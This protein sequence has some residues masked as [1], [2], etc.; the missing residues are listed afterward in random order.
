V[1]R[2]VLRLSVGFARSQRQLGL[3]PGSTAMRSVSATAR[4]LA[5]DVALPSR[6]DFETEF[7]PGRAYV[8][9]VSGQN[10]WVLYRFDD[11]YV[12]VLAVRESPPVPAEPRD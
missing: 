5:E 9:R 12:D 1:P 11:T 3:V 8:R 2:R 6:A 7:S 10:L 4:Q